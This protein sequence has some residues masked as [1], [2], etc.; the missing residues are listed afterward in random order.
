[1]TQSY[2]FCDKRYRHSAIVATVLLTLLPF[3][4]AFAIDLIGLYVGGAIGQGRVDANASGLVGIPPIPSLRDFSDNHSAYK[5]M[6]GVRP[7]SLFGAELAY[8]DLGRVHE[9][10]LPGLTTADVTM[11]GLTAFGMFY[12]P[13][14]IVDIYL[15]AGIARFDSRVSVTACGVDLC[16]T[17]RRT[18]NDS[19]FAGG[20]GVQ[21]KF[22]S[23]AVRGEYERFN[24]AGGNPSLFSLGVT[25]TF[26]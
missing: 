26:L 11:S 15:K 23:W 4:R 8:V 19:G 3:S 7:I 10:G 18:V 12:L 17:A 13:V 14:P 16:Q 5:V 22:G 21:L 24:A 20:A 2:S 1:M 25:K 6:V 9:P